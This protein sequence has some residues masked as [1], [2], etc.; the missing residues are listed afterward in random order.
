V[1]PENVMAAKPLKLRFTWDGG[2][3][4][5]VVA[6]E[7]TFI[8]LKVGII[9]L[10][11]CLLITWMSLLLQEAAHEASGIDVASQTREPIYE[12]RSRNFLT[13]ACPSQS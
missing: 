4:V 2:A 9:L 3:K 7:A 10:V 12:Q 8:Q 1:N 13:V 11:I 6:K 5:A